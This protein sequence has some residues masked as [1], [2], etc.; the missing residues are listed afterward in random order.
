MYHWGEQAA[1]WVNEEFDY[2][3]GKRLL[4]ESILLRIW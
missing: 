1:M 4:I 3:A 2:G